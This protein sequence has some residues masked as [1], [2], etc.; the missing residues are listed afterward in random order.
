VVKR[1]RLCIGP[2]RHLDVVQARLAVGLPDINGC[3]GQRLA[4]DVG[5]LAR[6]EA[7][8]AG[9]RTG[10]VGPLRQLRRTL[11]E[12]GSEHRA[13]GRARRRAVVDRIDQH[14]QAQGVRQQDEL[15]AL[16]VA[17]LSRGRQE[18]DRGQ[19]LGLR[20]LDF[21]NEAVQMAH[22]GAHHLRQAGI[23]AVGHPPAPRR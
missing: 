5:D 3:A 12:K 14:R 20:Q 23:A 15:L 22:Q 1:A 13:F 10:N 19:P 11:D 4:G 6:H 7:G 8:R 17:L 2:P 16:V 18:A 21:A 9:G